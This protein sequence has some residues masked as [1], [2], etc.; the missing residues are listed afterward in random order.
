MFRNGNGNT[1][2]DYYCFLNYRLHALA[3]LLLLM[4]PKLT[5]GEFAVTPNK[6]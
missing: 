3:Y 6:P 4:Q 5:P 1:T 2:I